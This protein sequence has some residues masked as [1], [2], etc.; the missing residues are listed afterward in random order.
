MPS[1]QKP[2]KL[3]RASYKLAGSAMLECIG[4][5]SA[6]TTS[7]TQPSHGIGVP[8]T[9]FIAEDDRAA[10]HSFAE[11]LAAQGGIE[12]IGTASSEIDAVDWFMHRQGVTDMLITD[13]LLLPGGSGFG[14]INHARSFKAFRRVVVFSA[15]A[16][17]A[18]EAKCRKLGAHAVFR[19]SEL[20]QLLGY[21]REQRDEAS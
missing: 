5:R 20:E 12:V 18:I 3:V 19:K 9:I 8:F 7:S 16:T 6:R 11:L 13:L 1:R 10:V 15:F 2:R 21:I 4:R 17:P 14:L